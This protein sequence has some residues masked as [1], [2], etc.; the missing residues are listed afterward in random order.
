MRIGVGVGDG[1]SCVC[2]VS[3][4]M[5][6][7]G[8]GGVRWFKELAGDKSAGCT[9]I[10]LEL[11]GECTRRKRRRMTCVFLVVGGVGTRRGDP[12]RFAEFEK[13]SIADTSF[14]P[15]C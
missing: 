4:C 5:R 9:R 11:D 2:E 1:D 7:S 14:V 13:V 12:L 15:P 6:K 8:V 3:A 10:H